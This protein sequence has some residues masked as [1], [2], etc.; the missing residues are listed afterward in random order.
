MSVDDPS[1]CDAHPRHLRLSAALSV[2]TVAQIVSAFG[3]QWYTVAHLG[4]GAQA[5]ALYAGG[6]LPQIAIALLMEPLGFVLIPFLSSKPEADR[7]RAGWP[8]LCA[9]AAVSSIVAGILFLI[10]PTVVP[11]LAPGLAE[12]TAELT[13]QLAQ[14]QVVGLIGSGCGTVLSCLSQAKGR[15]VWPALSVLICT[16]G[17]W[18]LLVVGLDR[19]GVWLAAWVQVAIVIGPGVLLLPV[20][21]GATRG[22]LSDLPSLLKEVWDRMRPLVA[23][24]SYNRTGFVVDRFLASLL[25][26]GSISI[27]DLVL[28]VHSAIGRVFNHGVVAPIVPQMARLASEKSWR[29]FNA[30]WRERVWWM[31][32]LSGGMV[33]VLVVGAFAV[34]RLNVLDH[35][36]TYGILHFGDL[37][38]M[39]VILMSCS[40][41]VLAGGIN[42][43]LV[44]AF[45]AQ[46]DMLT[47]AKIE[48]LT[49]TVGLI[50]KGVGA[51][52]GGLV[53][54]ATA[55]SFYYLLNSVMLG[56]VLR[57]RAAAQLL[58]NKV[59]ERN[60]FMPGE[61][62]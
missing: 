21:G 10:A 35:L 11:I 32:C 37:T 49:Y 56:V 30:L 57:R 45:Y 15:F 24:A 36:G 54:I 27:L 8:L 47:P 51:L 42:H 60:P 31:G 22:S 19:W 58:D 13:V 1:A 34:S 38:R 50:M 39:W 28:R 41:V 20:L 14:I 53:G 25:T 2:I 59:I 26:P 18:V 48:V 29:S 3:I 55:I 52:F 5:D 7:D 4:V 43:I 12:S 16:C 44:N 62:R 61:L 46:G 17:G 23:S 6:T 9:I 33:L 40:G